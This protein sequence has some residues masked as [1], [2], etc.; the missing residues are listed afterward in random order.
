MVSK[1]FLH[2]AQLAVAMLLVLIS[3]NLLHAQEAP[4]EHSSRCG[5]FLHNE[6]IEKDNCSLEVPVLSCRGTCYSEVTPIIYYQRFV[7]NSSVNIVTDIYTHICRPQDTSS[8]FNSECGC[9]SIIDDV[10]RIIPLKLNCT[11]NNSMVQIDQFF[12]FATK[13]AC[14]DCESL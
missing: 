3:T 10:S 13:C 7:K 4:N 8:P 1:I 14:T 9:C 2:V 12:T 5:L 6:L 11:H